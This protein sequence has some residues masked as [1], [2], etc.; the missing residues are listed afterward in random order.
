[1]SHWLEEAEKRQAAEKDDQTRAEKLRKK[2][3]KIEENKALYGAQYETFTKDLHQL[4]ERAAKLADTPERPFRKMESRE[5][6]SKLSNQIN[7]FY[8]SRRLSR[9]RWWTSLPFFN[10]LQFKHLRVIFINLSSKAG[11]CEIELK[12]NILLREALGVAR[13]LKNRSFSKSG[14]LHLVYPFSINEL[15]HELALEMIDWLAFVKEI[16]DCSFFNRIP[17]EEKHYF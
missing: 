13:T 3:V 15:N 11:Y 7:I 2:I 12:E 14:K 5:K 6:D 10:A 1:M 17:E 16:K 9:R 8:S 4:V